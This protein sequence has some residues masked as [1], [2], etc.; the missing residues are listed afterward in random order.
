MRGRN[1]SEQGVKDLAVGYI[2]R[3]ISFAAVWAQCH[4][5]LGRMEELG[6]GS[7]AGRG[8]KAV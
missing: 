2:R 6:S 4:S 5:L 8:R 1:I 3:R 7:A